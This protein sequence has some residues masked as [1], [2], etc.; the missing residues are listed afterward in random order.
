MPR[1]AAPAVA[2]RE[3]RACISASRSRWWSRKRCAP[4]RTPPTKSSSTTSRSTPSPTCA[5]PSQPGAP[6]LW[7]DA[8]GNIGFDWTAPADPDGK[9]QAALDR[10]FKEAAHVVRVELVNQR[11]VVASLEPRT[12]TA[13]Y[14]AGSNRYTLRCGTARRRR[15]ARAGRRRHGHQAGRVAR[16]HRRCRRRLRHEGLVLSGIRRDAAR[17]ARAAASRSIGCRPRSE[18]FVTDNQGRDSFW[19]VELALNERGKFLG[20]RVN[21]LGNI[22]AYFT[23]VAHF[24]FTTHISGCLPTVYDI[25]HAQVNTR[26]VFTNTLPTGPYR[27]AGRPEASYLLER[28][29]RCRRR[30]D[31]HRRRRIAP[32]QSDQAGENAVHHRVRQHLRQ[33]RFPGGIRAR[34]RARRL[35]RLCRAQ[36]GGEESKASCAAS[37]SAAISRSPAPFRRRP[38]ASRFPGGG[39]VTVSIG[40]GASGQGHQTVFGKVAA[41]RLGIDACGGHGDRRAIPPR[42]AG[43]RRGRLALGHVCRRRHRAYRRQSDREGQAR[44]RHAAAGGRGRRRLS[45]RQIQRARQ[46]R[47]VAV[48]GRRTRRRAEAARR[49]PGKPRHPGKVKVPP[50]FPNGC[51][52]AEVEIDADDRRADDRELCG[53][54]RLRQRARR[55]HRRGAD[56]RRRGARARPG[57]DRGHGLRRRRPARLRLVHGLRAAAR[58]Y[59]CR[60]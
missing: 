33:R 47:S 15:R 29:D 9:K 54:R 28:R 50:S 8:P 60:P 32:P 39:K 56:P 42:R 49:D 55:H 25:P 22:G 1:R 3:P 24:V 27:G 44:R 17:R 41:R 16:P 20:L 35:R 7:P 37:A 10:A 13:S 59:R 14:D 26:C 4:R 5:M 38:R 6:Q 19:T 43:L 40:A 52:V 18:A 46:P 51:H 45:R 53:G 23:G 31:R 30:S 21:C 58:R 36:E 34:A 48:R 57:A 2:R 12:A 11:L